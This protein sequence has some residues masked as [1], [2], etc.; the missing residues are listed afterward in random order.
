MAATDHAP[1]APSF[2]PVWGNCSAAVVAAMQN[3]TPD[4]PQTMEGTAAHWV[5]SSCLDLIRDGGEADAQEFIR[6]KAPNG[7]VIDD[8]MAEGAQV[9]IDEVYEH[10]CRLSEP[11]ADW[12]IEERVHMPHIHGQNWGTLDAALYLPERQVL[13]VWDYKHGHR[14]N[15]AEGNLQLIDYVEGLRAELAVDGIQDQELTVVIR[16]VQP[17]CYRRNG[18]VDEW[19]VKMSDLRAYAN[20]L[21]SKA[22]EAF[23]NPVMTTGLHCRD[24]PG[25]TTCAARRRVDYSLIDECD[26]PLQFDVMDNGQ[27]ATE[28]EILRDGI[29]VAKKRLDALHDELTHEIVSGNVVPGHAMETAEG[30]LKWNDGVSPQQA[31]AVANQFGFDIS[32]L[33]VKTP[34]QAKQAA[35]K[36]LRVQFGQILKTLTHRPPGGLKLVKAKDS[37]AAKAFKRK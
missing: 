3:P 10:V 34:T 25:K 26:K 2:A 32:K 30:R 20:R 18:P 9:F 22:E 13:F 6:Q 11:K 12:F 24:C 21:R 28:Y 35:P 4:T 5:A 36:A 15:D 1:L 8:K 17:F 7:V 29:E 16:I 37:K 31:N 23:T 33:E 27:K 19:V 14:Q